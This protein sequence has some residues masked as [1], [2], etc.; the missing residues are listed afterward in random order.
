MHKGAHSPIVY[1]KECYLR[2]ELLRTRFGWI[3][4]NFRFLQRR[5]QRR[6]GE[7]EGMDARRVFLVPAI[8]FSRYDLGDPTNG[9]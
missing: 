4:L 9:R 8:S 6:R 2:C 5:L 7:L 1:A 3:P